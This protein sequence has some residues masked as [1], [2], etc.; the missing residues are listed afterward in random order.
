MLHIPSRRLRR[1][2]GERHAE[3]MQGYRKR[4]LLRGKLGDERA[5]RPGLAAPA[6]DAAI[7]KGLDNKSPRIR[8]IPKS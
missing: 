6:M 4:S 5:R 3:K 7:P 1:Q 8:F 2:R